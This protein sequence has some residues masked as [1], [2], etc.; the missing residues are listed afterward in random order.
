VAASG[1][2]APVLVNELIPGLGTFIVVLVSL[3]GLIFN[4]GNIAG[5][6]LALQSLFGLPHATGAIMSA[7]IAVV[8][9]LVKE[10]GPVMDA[11]TKLLGMVMIG[12]MMYVA[13]TAH[14]PVASI[15]KHTFLP[16]KIDVL[17][18]ITLVGGTVGGYISFAGAHRM[19]DAGIAGKANLGEV[20]AGAVTGILLAGVMRILLFAAVAGVVAAGVVLPAENPAAKVF[21]SAAGI[22]G[23]RMF[24]VIL[25]SAAIT[26]VVAAAY[27]SVSF[28]AS[29]NAKVKKHQRVVIVGFILLSTGVF[30]LAG[31][32]TLLLVRAG[33]FNGLV[34][35]MALGAMLLVARKSTFTEGYRHAAWLLV[36]GWMVV[37]ALTIM[38]IRSVWLLL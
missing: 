31:S 3:G 10:F 36:T 20:N 22:A 16:E 9:F 12:L 11:F 13:F 23:L 8:I 32:P 37:I 25:W 18:I 5:S 21:E 33:T 38:G 29:V 34:L 35:P 2:K 6:S 14:P 24:G 17:S 19:L 7:V 27:T 15:V 26:S 4:I 30:L 1:K 28:M